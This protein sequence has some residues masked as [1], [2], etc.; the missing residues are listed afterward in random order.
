MFKAL[1][2]HLMIKKQPVILFGQSYGTSIACR[3]LMDFSSFA[4]GLILLGPSLAP[5][6]ETVYKIAPWLE[7]PLINWMLPRSIISA[8][9]EKMTHKD[10]LSKMLPLWKNIT[11]P[12]MY[13]QGEKDEL[14]N[15]SNAEFAKEQLVNVPYLDILMFKGESHVVSKSKQPAIRSKIFEMLELVREEKEEKRSRK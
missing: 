8:N 10:E 15:T 7:H 3:M 2:D 4:D 9:R 14:I 6:E 11:V 12:V 5:G 1:F 13:M